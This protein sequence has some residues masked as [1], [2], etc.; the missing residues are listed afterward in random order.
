MSVKIMTKLVNKVET[1]G[2]VNSNNN[3]S[4]LLYKI[5]VFL[6]ISKVIITKATVELKESK[7]AKQKEFFS[8]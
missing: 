5:K 2:V 6:Q 7:L 8:M 3:V 1:D 4:E